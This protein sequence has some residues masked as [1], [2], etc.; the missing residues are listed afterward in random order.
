VWLAGAIT[1]GAS[2]AFAELPLPGPQIIVLA[3]TIVAIVVSTRVPGVRAWVDSIPMGQLVGIHAVRFIGAVFL[4]L[5]A[6]GAMSP[7]FAEPAGW[8]DVV[9][10]IGAVA[11][12]VSGAPRTSAH[13]STYFAWN[14]FGVLDLVVAVGAATFV[15]VS[16]EIPG[17]EPITR[18]PLVI[19]PTFLVPLLFASHVA[20]YRRLRRSRQT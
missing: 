18:L 7:I 8:G 4:V 2:G 10:A 3:L 16:G 13:R 20:I 12:A 11:L 17:M 6:R 9:A 19:V 15:V 1:L 5:A 14:T